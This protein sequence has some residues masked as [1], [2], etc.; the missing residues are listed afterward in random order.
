[1]Y[2]Y[3]FQYFTFTLQ[4]KLMN[5]IFNI[6]VK[7][8]TMNKTIKKIGKKPQEELFKIGDIVKASPELTHLNDWV[9]G[10]IFNIIKNPFLGDEIAIKDEQGRIFFGEKYFFKNLKAEN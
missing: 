6:F 3:D 7:N 2:L 9:T 10:V 5:Q 4:L 8:K 1:M